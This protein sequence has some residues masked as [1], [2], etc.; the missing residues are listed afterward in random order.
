MF[1]ES[2]NLIDIGRVE[3]RDIKEMPMGKSYGI[4][5]CH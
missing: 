3:P 2:E 1:R 5:I 4:C